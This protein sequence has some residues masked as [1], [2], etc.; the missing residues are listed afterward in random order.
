MNYY[1]QLYLK[2]PISQN[3]FLVFNL[4]IHKKQS[5]P[6]C[7]KIYLL[8][9]FSHFMFND[10]KLRNKKNDFKSKIE[11]NPCFHSGIQN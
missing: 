11:N 6:I 5:N 3:R 1:L 7:Y 8:N 10:K 4:K 9:R 2:F